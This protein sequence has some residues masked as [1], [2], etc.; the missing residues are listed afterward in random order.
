MTGNNA[1]G[2][3]NAA[4]L[5]LLHKSPGYTS[6]DSLNR[7][8][9]A[10]G[11]RKVG[12]T[13]TL[14][15]FASGL[16]VVLAGWALKLSPWFDRCDKH[17]QGLIRFGVETDTL[18]SEGEPIARAAPPGREALEAALSR[19]RGDIMQ[20]PPAYSAIHLGGKRAHELARSGVEVKMEKRP[21]SIYKL[22]LRSYNPPDAWVYVHCSKGTY[23]RSLARDIAL[24]AGSRAHLSALVRSRVGGFDMADAVPMDSPD[25]AAALRPV[26]PETFQALGIPRI[27]VDG[28]V[29]KAM[30]QGKPLDRLLSAPSSATEAGDPMSA[31]V[32]S[33]E[34]SVTH[35]S[36][37][38]VALI[39]KKQGADNSRWSYGYVHAGA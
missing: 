18:D 17:Y 25:L 10:L 34:N 26:S 33:E 9:K 3:R 15:K 13:G 1:G 11:S 19:F 12:H 23:I 24:A 14:D 28:V 27:T 32:F 8:K 6:F 2:T 7:V 22:E 31:G 16:L 35:N 20:E 5:L 29:A 39:V 36:P 4:G 30:R 21:V 37:V 38:F